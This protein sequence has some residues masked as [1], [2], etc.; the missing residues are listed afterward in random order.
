MLTL[1]VFNLEEEYDSRHFKIILRDALENSSLMEMLSP[2]AVLDICE[3]I[4][5]RIDKIMGNVNSLS[6]ENE[7]NLT[8]V[9]KIVS[10]L[11]DSLTYVL[12]KKEAFIDVKNQIT[13]MIQTLEKFLNEHKISS[14]FKRSYWNWWGVDDSE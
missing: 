4:F 2:Q 7:S 11:I 14:R 3:T 10:L 9:R 13:L 12:E 8:Q 1:S 5:M 6:A